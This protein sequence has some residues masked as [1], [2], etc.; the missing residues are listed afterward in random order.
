MKVLITRFTIRANHVLYSSSASL[1]R[2]R[3][4]SGGERSL[5][6]HAWWT[7]YYVIIRT[8]F[9]KYKVN[10]QS[11]VYHHTIEHYISWDVLNPVENYKT[12]FSPQLLLHLMS[13]CDKSWKKWPCFK[14]LFLLLFL[15]I[16]SAIYLWCCA[17]TLFFYPHYVYNKC[18][19][20]KIWTCNYINTVLFISQ[21]M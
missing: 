6:S 1:S 7:I 16:C 14:F 15:N 17:V 12:T 4:I 20:M 8:I 5:L 9:I 2:G 19:V 10:Q 3:K 13:V 18:K 11:I 21:K